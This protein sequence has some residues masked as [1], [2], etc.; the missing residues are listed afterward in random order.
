MKLDALFFAAHPDDAELCCGGTIA[1]LSNNG[2]KTGIVDLTLGELGT[3]G[4]VKLRA[5]EA[6]AAG[7]LLGIS[8]RENLEFKDGNIEN[9]YA[10]RLKVIS[11]IRH[12]KPDI[13]FIPYHEDRHPDHTNTNKLIKEAVF[14]SGLEKIQTKRNGAFQKAH[15]PK[16]SI[17]YMQT[18]SFKPSFIIDI[19]EDYSL[20]KKAIQCYGSQFY[21]PKKSKGPETF[22]SNKNFS[23]FTEARATFYGF[24]IGVKY[25]EPYFTEQ[26]L[27]F[28]IFNLFDM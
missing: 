12:Y 9:T 8:V 21:N 25:G 27:K 14:F 20:K 1:K 13:V 10:N 22:I 16:K 23:D 18:Y 7:K 2:R 28:N 3:R 4:S 15:R 24:Q 6:S 5:K 17:Y 26:P 11:I 19:S